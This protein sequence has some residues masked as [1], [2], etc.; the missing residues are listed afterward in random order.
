MSKKDIPISA[1]AAN[2]KSMLMLR[3]TLLRVKTPPIIV[4][5]NVTVTKMK[6]YDIG[7]DT[8]SPPWRL[9]SAGKTVLET[10]P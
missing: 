8:I 5:K 3:M 1:P 7:K 6:P 9:I 2:A 4:E 10:V